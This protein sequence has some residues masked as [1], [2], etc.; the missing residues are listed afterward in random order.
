MVKIA[1]Q[2]ITS[3]IITVVKTSGRGYCGNIKAFDFRVVK[4]KRYAKEEVEWP[5]QEWEKGAGVVCLWSLFMACFVCRYCRIS[6]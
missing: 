3:R 4:E 2:T 5:D 6:L 1:I